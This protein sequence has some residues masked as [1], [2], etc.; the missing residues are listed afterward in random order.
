MADFN[1]NHITGKH[2]SQGPTIA[3]I[4]TVSSTGAMRIPNGRNLSR[5]IPEDVVTDG[6]IGYWDAGNSESYSGS[7]SSWY[8]LSPLKNTGTI[9]GATYS[10][11]NGGY[12]TLDGTNDLITNNYLTSPFRMNQRF[13]F[14]EVITY[15]IFIKLT[16]TLGWIMGTTTSGGHGSGG[17]GYYAPTTSPW[18]NT[19]E[20]ET[21]KVL[22]C[23]WTPTT[24]ESDTSWY[25]HMNSDPNGVWHHFVV[26]M[27]YS[28]KT[29]CTFYQDG[30]ELTKNFIDR[31]EVSN[32]V[33]AISYNSNANDNLAGGRYVNS[34]GY[35]PFDIAVIKLYD[36]ILSPEEVKQNFGAHRG[37]FSI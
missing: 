23:I 16:S 20:V 2:G 28:G 1:I 22:R 11:N 12:F 29:D 6:L 30:E 31:R 34:Q 37:R 35:T 10:S 19:T 13:F 7:G 33:P 36:R 21:N 3:G 8:D 15:D 17:I 24:P 14:S 5:Y 25:A 27:S 26:A 4:T 9:S 32:G 18:Y